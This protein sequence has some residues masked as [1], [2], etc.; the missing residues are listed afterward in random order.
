MVCEHEPLGGLLVGDDV[1]GVAAGVEA[2]V[3]DMR[4]GVPPFAPPLAPGRRGRYLRQ[5]LERQGLLYRG[6][7]SAS[8]SPRPCRPLA[9]RMSC[10][11]GAAAGRCAGMAC[12]EAGGFSAL[13]VSAVSSTSAG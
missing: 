11:S 10:P 8:L 6:P 7:H 13:P 12:W 1:H 2:A 9:K 5:F 4:P 3:A